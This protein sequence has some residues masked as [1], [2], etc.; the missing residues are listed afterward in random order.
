[1]RRSRKFYLVLTV[2]ILI[3]SQ[4]TFFQLP[5]SGWLERTIHREFTWFYGWR[6]WHYSIDISVDWYIAYA[7][8]PLSDRMREA[9]R[10]W[11]ALVTVKDPYLQRIANDLKFM[12]MR[13]GYDDYDTANFIL[14]FV[15]S[16]PYVPD[17]VSTPYDEFPKFPLETIVEGGGDCEDTSILYVTLM[18]ILGYDIAL[19]SFPGHMMT[20]VHVT[21]EI[22]LPSYSYFDVNGRKYYPAETT[23]EGWRV[24]MLPEDFSGHLAR[25]IWPT[26]GTL[27]PKPINIQKLS[28]DYKMLQRKYGELSQ[29][30][31]RLQ[32]EYASLQAEH[33]SALSQ[34]LRLKEEYD[35]LTIE[36][37]HLSDQLNSLKSD[38]ASLEERYNDLSENYQRLMEEHARLNQEHQN[39]MNRH[40]QLTKQYEEMS[41][42]YSQVVSELSATRTLINA[43][44]IGFYAMIIIAAILAILFTAWRRRV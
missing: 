18:K 31:D 29:E 16:L 13:E 21:S 39:L 41:A 22:P 44:M 14:A 26:G 8:V 30:Y 34:L 7:M 17:D 15:Q 32:Q 4:I 11:E 43:Y 24:G 36:L 27:E 42:S 6:E 1:M 23:G 10:L 33:Q 38:Y 40:E 5:A 37:R 25:L 20:A 19:V 12:A 35:S 28:E 2:F 3:I 9:V